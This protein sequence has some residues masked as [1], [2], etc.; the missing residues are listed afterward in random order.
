MYL[1][2]RIR[3]N[4]LKLVVIFI[5]FV[6]MQFQ[7]CSARAQGSPAASRIYLGFDVACGTRSFKLSSD[8]SKLQGRRISQAGMNGGI[9]IGNNV[10][11]G[12]LRQGYYR[13]SS[14][15]SQPFDL[16]ESEGILNLNALQALR[17]K[18]RYFEP[19]LTTGI[20]RNSLKIY[21]HFVE[22]E[23]EEE[24]ITD[25]DC[26][27]SGGPMGGPYL[28]AGTAHGSTS[29]DPADPTEDLTEGAVTSDTRLAGKIIT[30]RATIGL[31]LKC[32]VPGK[33]YFLILYSEVKYGYALGISHTSS[34]LVQTKVSNQVSINVGISFGLRR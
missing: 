6:I 9:I 23:A 4:G 30:S 13:S 19:Y 26:K 11:S 32:N 22:N 28:P 14:T 29:N 24:E 12:K 34:T 7:S 1:Q 33:G 17:R 25:E 3:M 16:I 27:S 21:G 5:M 18:F 8:I 15:F 10:V 2:D 20:E 31:G